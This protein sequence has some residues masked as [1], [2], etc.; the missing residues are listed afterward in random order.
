MD[1]VVL[2]FSTSAVKSSPR[3]QFLWCREADA[4]VQ[5]GRSVHRDEAVVGSR[6]LRGEVCYHCCQSIAKKKVYRSV[7]NY[8]H[9]SSRVSFGPGKFCEPE[10]VL[11]HLEETGAP[12]NSMAFTRWFLIEH[13]KVPRRRI[14][15]ALPRCSL[16]RFGGMLNPDKN[17][18][19]RTIFLRGAGGKEAAETKFFSNVRG[20]PYA[21]IVEVQRAKSLGNQDPDESL[22]LSGKTRGL[23]RP[24]VRPRDTLAT[25]RP[26]GEEPMLLNLFAKMALRDKQ[27]AKQEEREPQQEQPQGRQEE[28]AEDAQVQEAP[29]PKRTRREAPRGVLLT[30]E[31]LSLGVATS[32]AKPA[33]SLSAK[34]SGA[35]RRARVVS[36]RRQKR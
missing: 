11:G 31:S 12:G 35:R 20:I 29:A 2:S 8:D 21:M 17:K 23:R 14:K 28:G 36:R 24:E 19:H 27:E 13:Y 30:Q 34:S 6:G 1:D 18:G 25:C 5:E 26:T 9:Y 7:A 32:R 15:P 33:A 4:A 16:S 10:C 3:S 22:A